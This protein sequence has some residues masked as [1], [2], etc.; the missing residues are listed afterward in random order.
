M[1]LSIGNVKPSTAKSVVLLEWDNKQGESLSMRFDVVTSV[2]PEDTVDISDHPVEEGA[3]VTDH[4]RTKLAR[5]TIEAVTS[6]SPNPVNDPDAKQVNNAGNVFAAMMEEQ[7]LKTISL[8]IPTPPVQ[9]SESGVIQAGIGAIKNSIFG[10]PKATVRTA[11][12][13]VINSRSVTVIQRVAGFSRPRD[14]YAQLLFLKDEHTLLHI[15]TL[16][17][18]YSKMMIERIA[19]PRTVGDGSNIKFQIDFK[20]IRTVS[21]LLVQAPQPVE[22]RA[23]PVKIVGVQNA[24]NAGDFLTWQPGGPPPTSVSKQFVNYLGSVVGKS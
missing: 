18:E 22:P 7:K 1:T 2:N 20:E 23:Q 8:N 12:K 3:D 14:V 16:H 13:Q 11:S 4:A 19:S 24:Q 6:L 17:R 9:L 5:L 15:K 10:A 21:S